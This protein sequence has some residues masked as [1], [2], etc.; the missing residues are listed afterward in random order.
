[1]RMRSWCRSSEPLPSPRFTAAFLPF[2]GKVKRPVVGHWS[3]LRSHWAHPSIS[4]RA[5]LASRSAFVQ[6]ASWPP[7]WS[8]TLVSQSHHDNKRRV[9]A[10]IAAVGGSCVTPE[11]FLTTCVELTCQEVVSHARGVYSASPFFKKAACK[12]S[13]VHFFN[14]YFKLSC[15]TSLWI[16]QEGFCLVF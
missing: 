5:K 12:H 13:C 16:L 1:M 7:A 10:N 6:L 11:P 15:N 2:V 3:A 14:E 4:V 9:K 8:S